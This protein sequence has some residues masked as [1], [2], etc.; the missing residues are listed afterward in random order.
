MMMKMKRVLCRSLP[1]HGR[2]FSTSAD[3]L[4]NAA[5][6]QP[7][8][9]LV[10]NGA[11]S[12]LGQAIIELAKKRGIKTIN[13]IADKPGT[14]LL[15]EK[16]KLKGGD[17]VVS[18]S[19]TNTWFIKRLLSDFPKPTFGLNCSDGFAATA[20][21]KLLQEGGTLLT[22]GNKLPQNIVYPGTE[23]RPIPWSQYLKAKNLKS[24]VV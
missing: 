9:V 8:D 18:E 22:Y 15:V 3:A 1:P 21:A 11:D 17:I 23:R 14:P 19:Y 2:S 20:V 6:L 7:G 10:Q 13:V 16:L 24:Q 5:N 12:E 4:L